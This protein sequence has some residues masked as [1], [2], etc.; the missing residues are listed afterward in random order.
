M[1]KLDLLS[2]DDKLIIRP[3]DPDTISSG[4]VYLPD[5]AQPEAIFGE[6]VAVGPGLKDITGGG[7]WEMMCQV[8]DI[9]YYPK[10]GAHKFEIENEEYVVI[11]EVDLLAIKKTD[12]TK[13]DKDA[14]KQALSDTVPLSDSR[15]LLLDGNDK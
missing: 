4:G 7:H 9:V 13:V 5:G 11:R 8:G 15:A 1:K 12:T 2:I 10:F 3:Q 6:V 14:V